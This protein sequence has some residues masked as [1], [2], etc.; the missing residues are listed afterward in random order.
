M[1]TVCQHIG[2]VTFGTC[3]NIDGIGVAFGTYEICADET[4]TSFEECIVSSFAANM[5]SNS[6]AFSEGT[7]LEYVS[8]DDLKF[9]T[10]R[11]AP[12]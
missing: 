7:K 10:S 4:V 3:A 1:E 6:L 11:P 8:S 9:W 2:T 12:I 5:S